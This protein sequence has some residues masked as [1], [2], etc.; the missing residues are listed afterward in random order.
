MWEIR[1][2]R[3]HR[4]KCFLQVWVSR[5]TVLINDTERKRREVGQRQWIMGLVFNALTCSGWFNGMQSCPLI[6]YPQCHLVMTVDQGD[7]WS[8][9]CGISYFLLLHS[10]N[11]WILCRYC[12]NSN[13]FTYLSNQCDEL[14]SDKGC[15]SSLQVF[16]WPLMVIVS[17]PTLYP[18]QVRWRCYTR[19]SNKG[20]ALV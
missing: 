7:Y 8:D 19:A 3:D 18:A 4:L 16:R 2:E 10:T 9:P 13:W 14:D 12:C 17:A 15:L 11:C 20:K 6:Q 5:K 1:N